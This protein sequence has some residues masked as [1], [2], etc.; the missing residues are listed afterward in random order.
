MATIAPGLSAV[1]VIVLVAFDVSAVYSY[2]EPL[3]LGESVSA[4]TAS[5]DR[6]ASKGL[7]YQPQS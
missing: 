4:P 2:T 1:A 7:R 3:K 6:D 5:D